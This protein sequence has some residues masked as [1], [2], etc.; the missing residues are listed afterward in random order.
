MDQF[1]IQVSIP[2]TLKL[3]QLGRT[4]KSLAHFS[5]KRRPNHKIIHELRGIY[6]S[7]EQDPQQDFESGKTGGIDEQSEQS[8]GDEGD[9]KFDG[10]V[11][12]LRERNRSSRKH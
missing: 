8:S 9:I 7:A 6:G 12:R 1:T 11:E 2:W 10:T 4:N 3:S 5:Y